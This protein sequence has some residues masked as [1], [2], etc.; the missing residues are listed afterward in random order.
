MIKLLILSIILMTIGVGLLLKVQVRYI[1]EMHKN[2]L[3]KAE[4]DLNE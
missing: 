1:Q 3:Q 4:R 2:H